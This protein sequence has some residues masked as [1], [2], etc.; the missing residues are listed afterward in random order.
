VPIYGTRFE[1]L[2]EL[3]SLAGDKA[4][5]AVGTAGL[6]ADHMVHG[7][8]PDAARLVPELVA[9]VE[10]IGDPAL[11]VGVSMSVI[12]MKLLTGE[13]ADVLRW[14]QAVIDLAGDDPVKGN[15]MIG[16][17]LAAAYASRSLARCALGRPDW[18]DDLDQAVALAH[19]ADPMSVG[20]VI[21]Y[22]YSMFIGGG[23]FLPDDT[24]MRNLEEALHVAERSADDLALG[25]ALMTTGVALL[26]SEPAHPEHGLELLERVREMALH[27]GF[28]LAHLP[29]I[30]MWIARGMFRRGERD[31]AL[32]GLRDAA[33]ELLDS[34][35]LVNCPVVTGLLVETLLDGGD[36]AEVCEAE[37][38]LDRLVNTP[39]DDD[40]VLRDLIVLRLRAL[41][42]RAN[43][44]E[45]GFRDFVNRYRRRANDVGYEGHI[46]MAQAM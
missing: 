9:L 22:T 6:I 31:N 32:T 41:I 12:P 42:A 13:V 43:G 20:V 39:L 15:V 3:C 46:A 10:S 18:R 35:Q 33:D 8:I 44:D 16:S 34:G 21:T 30:Y 4:S 14:S 2:R 17:P 40:F 36:A 11:T 27:G 45:D 19:R 24:V 1:E 7:R 23:V 25:F 26:H 5:L 37:A 29:A 38:A 28:Y